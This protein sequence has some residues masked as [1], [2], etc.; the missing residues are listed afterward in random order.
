MKDGKRL[1]I[2][3]SGMAGTA[4]VEEL[5]KTGK[6]TFE[7]TVLGKER[8]PNYNRVLLSQVLTGEKTLNDITT[9]APAW[10]DKTGVRLL[11]GR[12]VTGINRG[13]RV[14][15]T[16]DG[17]EERYDKLI[18]ALGSS[19]IV[20]DIPGAQKD[21]VVA[22]RNIDDCER[23]RG[24]ATKGIKAVVIGGGLLGLE[25]AHALRSMGAEV[26]VV[27]LADRL[28]ERQLDAAA[29]GFLKEDLERA[30]MRIL[31]NAETIAITGEDRAS[32]VRFKDGT[33]IDAGVVVMCVGIRPNTGLAE[34]SGVYCKRGIVVSDTMQ[35]Y[36]P[37]IYA[38]GECVEHRGTTFGLVA[39][40]FEQAR[41]AANHLAGDARLTFKNRPTAARLK[42]QGIDL[43]SAG[44]IDKD[45][46]GDSI[47]YCDRKEKVYKRVI[48]REGKISGIIMYGDTFDGPKLFGA[49]TEDADV[50]KI[51]R[52]L[53]LGGGKD[54]APME[55][56][57]ATVVCGCNGVT[58]GMIR[59][60]IEK[61]SLFTV[62]D[63]KR[64]TK[65]AT[66]CGG[67]S[68]TVERILEE[69]L[70]SNFEAKA[71]DAG[72]CPCT[73]YARED[74]VKNIRERELMSVSE[75][76]D[77]LGWE[78]VGCEICRPAINYYVGMVWPKGCEDDATSRLV[79][80]RTHANIQKDGR[81]SVVPR[82]Y[83]GAATP[84]EL[85]KIA[86]AAIKYNAALV[87]ITGGQRIALIGVR[88]EDLPAIWNDL[89]M[90]SG[91]AYGKALRTVK[92]CVG[93]AFCRY[94][95]QDSL[96]LGVELEKRLTG[97]WMPA[98]VKLSVSGCPRNCS[99][100][101]IKDIGIVG[102]NGGWEIYA[103]GCGGVELKAGHHLCTVKTKEEVIAIVG[104]FIQL[105]R[106]EAEY[107]ERTFKWIRRAGLD[108]IKKAVVEDAANREALVERL[109]LAL[110]AATDPWKAR[111][112]RD[113]RDAGDMM[114][115]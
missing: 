4:C 108:V 43:Y 47:E 16:E 92:T 23:L 2:V 56:T 46:E 9:H 52:S 58:K 53:L 29:A 75:V 99:E 66:S 76:M 96:G 59:E 7:I 95:T 21:G 107:T 10:Y 83:G 30:G 109:D 24:L 106:E 20:P 104:A 111:G 64:E 48:L 113:A 14:I 45:V 6:G 40:V 27:H 57:D 82:L 26:T 91:Y 55:M 103:G 80:E 72:L 60:A 32:G 110:S 94:G 102:I 100:S 1:V 34:K 86:D 25:A 84:D 19:P 33:G 87:K 18:L 5:I 89:G 114:R 63:V 88:K 41:V 78:T 51:R 35:T 73:K 37:A 38:V 79:N 74:I 105:Y 98:K 36:D 28:M 93:A 44:A 67:C 85:K 90:D 70:G 13:K 3:G 61:K 31:L 65:A 77:T 101:A 42:I 39:Q 115:A 17:A 50:S 68:G 69:T 22:F 8:H 97:L 62:E 54:A 12:K 49:L 11:L 81:F 71:G 112:D 15:V